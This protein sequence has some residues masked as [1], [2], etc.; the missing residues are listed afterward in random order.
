MSILADF[1]RTAHEYPDRDAVVTAGRTLSYR[2]LD[3]L[4]VDFAHRLSAVHPPGWFVGIDAGRG[5]GAIVAMLGSM[6]A[7]RPFVFLD[8][9]DSTPSNA[10]KVALLG[11]VVLAR[12]G[13]DGVDLDEVPGEWRGHRPAAMPSE[14]PA[15]LCYAIHTS[16]TTGEP[17]CVLV[18]EAPLAAVIRDHVERLGVGPASRTL[19]FARLTFDGCVTEI[20]WTLTAGACLVVLD[21]DQLTPGTVL[22]QTL[23][24]YR[25]SH[26]KTTPF[27]LTATEPGPDMRLSRVVN[28]GGAC[29]AAV[30]RKWSAVARFHNAYG[31]T[32]TTV[33]N[34]LTPPL[35]PD[36]CSDGVPLGDTV[37]RCG[38]RIDAA[39]P[40]SRR[41]ELVITGDSVAVGYLT[42]DGVRPFGDDYRT[43]DIVRVSG[44]RLH[45]VERIDRQAKVRGYR[46]DLGEVENAVCALDAVLDAVV[47]VEAHDGSSAEEPDALVCY[48]VG[49]VDA[50]AVRHH[51]ERSLDPYKV[52]SVLTRVERFPYTANGKIDRDRL[53]EGRW[54]PPAADTGS[55]GQQVL[56]LARRLTGVGDVGLEDNFFEVGGDSS[57]ALALVTSMREL[58]WADA[59]VRD[60]LRAENLQALAERLAERSG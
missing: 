16:G 24:R 40:G 36:E 1:E 52:P 15:D 55:P 5:A 9:R 30:V 39:E 28:G 44:G 17:K 21:E 34:L 48:F 42:E 35:D 38:Y 54:Q 57:S 32:E 47:T 33:C 46:L 10:R 6:R 31:T 23:E 3:R 60:V 29:R 2:E 13:T 8:S 50:R 45:Y 11:T 43:G 19:Q 56:Q 51:L 27:A 25:I 26:L 4:T 18:R 22:R 12:P 37:G 59:G 53:R 14:L 41:G 20:L 49:D 7:G 58:G